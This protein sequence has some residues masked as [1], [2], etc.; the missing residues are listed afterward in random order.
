VSKL[1][2]PKLMQLLSLAWLAISMGHEHATSPSLAPPLWPRSQII[3][4]SCH[5]IACR[6]LSWYGIYL[7]IWMMILFYL[8]VRSVFMLASSLSGSQEA[9]RDSK[10]LEICTASLEFESGRASFLRAW[11]S[12]GFTHSPEPTKYVF[13]EMR[14]PWIQKKIFIK[15]SLTFGK[16]SLVLWS[17]Q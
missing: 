16:T 11:D 15:S 7:A 8:T 14:F 1:F 3:L 9:W 17:M 13:Q 12:R 5:I 4:T 2:H 6:S 10:R